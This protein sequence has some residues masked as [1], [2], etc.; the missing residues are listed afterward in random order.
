MSEHTR[1][2]R[3]FIQ[4]I[5]IAL[6]FVSAV[7]LFAQTQI[8]GLGV[9]TGS[10]LSGSDLSV[11]IAAPNQTEAALTA[12]VRVVATSAFGRYGSMA[13][14][15]D[16]DSFEPLRGLLEQALL[17]AQDYRASNGH[18]FFNALKSTSIYYDFLV[19]L[20]LPVLAELV[21][22]DAEESV[23]ARRLILAGEGDGVSLYLWDDAAGYY[24]CDTALSPEILE[25]TV[26]Q[27]ELGNAFFAFE[28]SDPYVQSVS[29]YSL[30]L[31]PEPVLP[32]LS[33][34]IPLSDSDRLLLSLG[35]NPNTQY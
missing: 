28:S 13:L 8:Y 21:R 5:T 33:I 35:F 16:S 18:S 32:E 17:S 6:L 3:D 29:P 2:H 9:H 20:P 24:R 30:F 4:N 31:D 19:P 25:Q 22:A 14:T 7:L 12:P 34:S 15:T 11:D 27:Y 26:N 10:F 23:S 1:K